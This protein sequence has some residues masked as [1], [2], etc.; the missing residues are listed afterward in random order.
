VVASGFYS[1]ASLSRATALVSHSD[2]VRVAVGRMR[3]TLI[4]A[5]TGMRGYLAAS[6]PAFL[7]PYYRALGSWRQDLAR[8]RSMTSD[9]PEQQARLYR[10]RVL[11][12]ETFSDLVAAREAH[13]A[14]LAGPSLAPVL[15]EQKKSM[16]EVR[17]V[18]DEMEREEV[19]LDRVRE[20]AANRH[21]RMTT[22]VIAAGSLAFL[23]A[24]ATAW[25][26]RRRADSRRQVTEGILTERRQ[27]EEAIDAERRLLQAVLAGIEDGIAL[28]DRS[29]KVIFANA[30][31][32]R[33]IGYAS[34]DALVAAPMASVMNGFEVLDPEG[35][36]LP[37]ERLPSRIVLA[38]GVSEAAATLRYRVR[39]TG[40]ERWSSVRA[41]PIVDGAGHTTQAICVFRDVTE[42]H[43]AA[44]RQRFLLRA[45]DELSSS[46][47]YE[48]TL[49]KVA[50]LAV[51]TLGDW[52]AVD[53][54]ED[55][56]LKRVATSHSDP[57]K[58]AIARELAARYPPDPE[59]PAG[60]HEIV[61]TGKPQL[62]SA[63]PR[64]MLA[65]AA[66]DDE[67]LRL[68]E[69][70]EL[71]SYIGV[72]LMIGTRVIGAISLA[73]AESRRSY[74]EQDLA[75]AQ[76]LADRAALAI[77]NARLYRRVERP[78]SPPPRG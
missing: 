10:M 5:E 13:R 50:Q 30:S 2:D 55:L 72:P 39:A 32:A 51:P 78:G 15:L 8:L 21:W 62:I 25:E 71:R 76:A 67:H 75:F 19:R 34:S 6:D 37:P 4:D 64:E 26:Q 43:R 29:G 22:G 33:L 27:A 18:I 14:G 44:E 31:G 9:N 46:L 45:V 68:M 47:D 24:V 36:H 57:A 73:T 48:D 63:I 53:V 59:A 70:L 66:V 49:A 77:E 17:S 16:D 69:A 40:E 7:E 20:V 3:A 35:G 65:E 23:V 74:G 38:G 52:C 54:V 61:R 56:H 28:L 12:D 1:L 42:E 41:Y 58:V 60:P 11:I